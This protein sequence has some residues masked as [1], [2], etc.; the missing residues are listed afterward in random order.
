MDGWEW[1][2]RTAPLPGT[3][4]GYQATP[5]AKPMNPA[6]IFR[7]ELLAGGLAPH[8]VDGI[9]MNGHDESGFNPTAL[10][11][12]GNAFGIL[13]WNGP[14]M[15]AL[16]EFAAS[17]GGDA[18]D[19]AIQA[20]FTLY[21]LNGPEKAAYD[22]LQATTTAGEAGAAFVNH[23]ERPAETHRARREAA[24]LGGKGS[25]A[26]NDAARAWQPGSTPPS[27]A[28]AGPAGAPAATGQNQLAPA[29]KPQWSYNALQADPSAFFSRSNALYRPI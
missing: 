18:A 9:M 7:S 14:R 10:G 29:E 21:E 6:D 2:Q 19:P 17:Q 23:Y 22:R 24:Y 26:S 16:K 15:R 3:P 12:N 25:Y 27:N 20:R 8:I 13:Q 28:F 1:T 11:D 4:E 5:Q